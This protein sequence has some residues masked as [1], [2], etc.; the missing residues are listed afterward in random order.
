M[1][2][3]ILS[4]CVFAVLGL[5]ERLWP[6]RR[7]PGDRL[8]NLQMWGLRLLIQFGVLPTIGLLTAML[9]RKAGVRL[10]S[11]AEW[12]LL[13]GFLAYLVVA[14][15]S[16][17]LFHRAQH[18]IPILW[19]MHSLHHSDPSVNATTAECHWWGDS[20]V[21]A[22]TIWP[23]V[24]FVMGPGP[25][26]YLLYGLASFYHYFIH[27]NLRV[28]FG[29]LSWALNSPAYHRLH[30][31]IDPGD[32][33]VNYAALFPIFDV[34]FGSYR[35]PTRFAQTGLA[36]RPTSAVEAAV[37]PARPGAGS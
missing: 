18:T 27:A 29:G 22:V 28:N 20:L 13:W 6:A 7:E 14:D 1:A 3:L 9:A 30:H 35:R 31:S 37:W 5:L 32:Y 11:T 26:I 10:L 19:K 12:P 36:H 24:A 34:L 25:Q 33:G 17:Y 16:E 21:K 8:L 15:F 23:A 4:I 2:F